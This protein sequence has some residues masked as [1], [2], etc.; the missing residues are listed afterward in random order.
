MSQK[1]PRTW[2]IFII[3]LSLAIY[4]VVTAILLLAGQK[5]GA[6]ISSQEVSEVT[7]IF[8]NKTLQLVLKI[9]IAVVLLV[10]GVA[11][12]IKAFGTDLGKLDD[13]L[14]IIT[15]IVWIAVTVIALVAYAKTDFKSGGSV[16]HWFLS[17]AKNG[18]II[19]G[20]I[21]IKNGK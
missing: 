16:F 9:A 21:T 14:K 15:L 13:V 7:K 3:Q 1:Q 17:L 10:Y 19:G 20:I 5:L 4:F 11:L 2:G 6:S 18:L 12:L 8:S